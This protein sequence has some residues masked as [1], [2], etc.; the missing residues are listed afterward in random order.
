MI[1]TAAKPS[2]KSTLAGGFSFCKL[3]R[4]QA[5]HQNM[6]TSCDRFIIPSSGLNDA[7]AANMESNS[8]AMETQYLR[9]K[10]PIT[11][12]AKTLK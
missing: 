6:S 11:P 4:I 8:T 10:K 1:T 2:T 7:T 9:R 5:P 3:I 12:A